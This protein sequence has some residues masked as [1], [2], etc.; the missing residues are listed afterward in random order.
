[1]LLL[2]IFVPLIIL[3]EIEQLRTPFDYLNDDTL[4]ADMFATFSDFCLLINEWLYTDQFLRAMLM[5]DF[6]RAL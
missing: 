2:V 3:Y 4:Y 6:R 5:L 1:M